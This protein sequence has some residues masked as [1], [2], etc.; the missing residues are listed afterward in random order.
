MQLITIIDQLRCTVGYV[1]AWHTPRPWFQCRTNLNRKAFEPDDHDLTAAHSWVV[2]QCFAAY[3]QVLPDHRHSIS[4]NSESALTI[5]FH[6]IWSRPA[7]KANDYNLLI[8]LR[9]PFCNKCLFKKHQ[10]MSNYSFFSHW[11]GWS[12]QATL[13]HLDG[14]VEQVVV[15]FTPT[16]ER[17]SRK[18]QSEEFKSI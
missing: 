4:L 15:A 18:I 17:W 16:K 6:Q 14:D 12:V 1:H 8:E 5:K 11:E 9:W 3:L 13:L 2:P 7:W 10:R